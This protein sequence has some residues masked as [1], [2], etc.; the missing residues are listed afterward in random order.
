MTL[1]LGAKLGS[2]GRTIIISRH[3]RTRSPRHLSV[4]ALHFQTAATA[5][6]KHLKIPR[7]G[8]L[9]IVSHSAHIVHQA[10][11]HPAQLPWLASSS[12]FQARLSMASITAAR[13]SPSRTRRSPYPPTLGRR[14]KDKLAFPK[15]QCR[16]QPGEDYRMQAAG[17]SRAPHQTHLRAGRLGQGHTAALTEWATAPLTSTRSAPAPR[18]CLRLD[19]LA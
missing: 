7:L 14:H 6:T 15:S 11:I 5:I 12:Q 2:H 17:T 10:D 8:H 4:A 13:T 9:T 19:Q 16:P 3:P 1:D 18:A